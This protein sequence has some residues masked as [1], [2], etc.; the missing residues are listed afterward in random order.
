MPATGNR[1]SPIRSPNA[2]PEFPDLRYQT[3]LCTLHLA[4]ENDLA[5]GSQQVE[6][7]FL[8]LS[9]LDLE[10]AGHVSSH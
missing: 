3:V 8:V 7:V 2:W 4:G 6:E 9:S 1:I 5:I 10:F